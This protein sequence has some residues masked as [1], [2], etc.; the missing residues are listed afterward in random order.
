[1]LKLQNSEKL[2]QLNNQEIEFNKLNDQ[3]IKIKSENYKLIENYEKLSNDYNDVLAKSLNQDNI[4]NEFEVIKNE[5]ETLKESIKELKKEKD[6]LEEKLRS[7]K[8]FYC[9]DL[10]K[11][12][13][14]IDNLQL[15]LNLSNDK[16]LEMEKQLSELSNEIKQ[17]EEAVLE[18]Q[19]T[20]SKLNENLV[21]WKN[22]NMIL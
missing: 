17:I 22:S 5:N 6:E 10:D 14:L 12:K 15:S 11:N 16:K 8:D 20:N 18:N 1:M 21:E 13:N 19:D 2:D 9:N 4:S 3:L 7:I